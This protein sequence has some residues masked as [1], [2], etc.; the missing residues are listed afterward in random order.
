MRGTENA[1]LGRVVFGSKCSTE[2]HSPVQGHIY[3]LNT[4]LLWGCIP[5][6]CSE[7]PHSV[8]LAGSSLLFIFGC[9]NLCPVLKSSSGYTNCINY[10]VKAKN[11]GNKTVNEPHP[12]RASSSQYSRA[13]DG[14]QGQPCGRVST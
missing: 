1:K 3:Q 13:K 7:L 11:K 10:Q 6:D 2:A 9:E 5:L 4:C 12:L 14:Q 8:E